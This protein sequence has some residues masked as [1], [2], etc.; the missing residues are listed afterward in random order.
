MTFANLKIGHRLAIGFGLVIA[1]MLVVTAIGVTQITR[2]NNSIKS[3]ARDHY[4]KTVMANTIKGALN[5]TSR[6]MRNVLFLSVA[7]EIA[8]ELA[9]IDKSGALIADT[10]A[11]FEKSAGSE[12]DKKLIAEVKQARERY[13][14]ILDGYVKLIKDG[15][16]EQARDLTL[17]EIAP[18]QQ[19]YFDA[20]DKLIEFEGG[21]MNAAGSQAEDV[22]SA[23]RMLMITLA[24]AAGILA[25]AI[26]VLVT[27]SITRPLTAAVA[28]AKRVA[29]GD[30]T[31][32]VEVN[33][34]DETGELLTA[35]RDM[36]DSLTDT[37][38]RVRAG[39]ETIAVAS[40][41]IASGNTDLSART[42]TQ[43]SSLQETA[44]SMEELTQTVKQN[45]E[46]AQQ[47][48]Q[49]V[50][51][52]SERAVRGGQVVGQV[53]STMGSIKDSSRKIV[54]IIGVIDGIAFQTNILALNA[55]VEAARA[56][57][58]GRGFA[59][60]AAE[61]RNLA[62]RSAGAAK[63]IK[64]LISDSVEKVEA[65]GKLVDDAGKTMDEIVTSV[66]HVANIMREITAASDEQSTGIEE[67]NR[68][69]AQMDE[70]TQ[71]NAALVEQA[72]AAADSMRGQAAALAQ[73]VSVFKLQQDP[74]A[75]LVLE[76]DAQ[77]EGKVRRL[78]ARTKAGQP[79]GRRIAMAQAE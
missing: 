63:E 72:A 38:S 36:N 15:Q 17:P 44:S 78:P 69:I 65:G 50:S 39:T 35:L 21:L 68:A 54:D 40:R 34:R 61:V 5:D 25:L 26:S 29:G 77:A 76:F 43:A 13:L 2:I 74:S 75:G 66:M 51:T 24:S 58:Q 4:P 28:V 11:R 60:V 45:A 20:L 37:V 79:A 55:A 33:G 8:A 9:A 18:F 22:A 10:L 57:E 49:L 12:Q 59:V 32:R 71:Q 62:Q 41:E 46:N 14:P 1:L 30:L 52:A 23:T 16:I 6:S 47:A 64:A 67:I 56:G 42:E 70:M 27:R 19:K 53:V 73:S 48:N 3:M 31:T 7:T